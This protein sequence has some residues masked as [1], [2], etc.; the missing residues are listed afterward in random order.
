MDKELEE[1]LNQGTEDHD[2]APETITENDVKMYLEGELILEGKSIP[3][4][5]VT[6]IWQK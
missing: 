2:E 5:E 4:G 1:T 6:K 3:I